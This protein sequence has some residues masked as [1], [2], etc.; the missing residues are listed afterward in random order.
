LDVDAFDPANLQQIFERMQLAPQRLVGELEDLVERSYQHSTGKDFHEA[1]KNTLQAFRQEMVP[2]VS[3]SQRSSQGI[4]DSPPDLISRNPFH[5]KI[6]SPTMSSAQDKNA[7]VDSSIIP[8]SDRILEKMPQVQVIPN[9]VYIADD[10]Q[11]VS[12]W[13]TIN[14]TD[15]NETQFGYQIEDTGT[16]ENS[17]QPASNEAM[18]RSYAVSDKATTSSDHNFTPSNSST[19]SCVG[20]N[21]KSCAVLATVLS[22]SESE[23]GYDS[24]EDTYSSVA[25]QSCAYTDTAQWWGSAE[26]QNARPVSGSSSAQIS[27]SGSNPFISSTRQSSS[28]M[29][30]RKNGSKRRRDDRDGDEDGDGTN[31]EGKDKEGSIDDQLRLACPFYARAPW[32]ARK[33]RSCR[34]PG[35]PTVH[36]LK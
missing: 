33:E 21:D 7:M 6:S 13:P 29:R 28:A 3:P 9:G 22:S 5:K 19:T 15:S 36:R 10:P 25:N 27:A 16:E 26:G 12:L 14:Q 32:K 8:T 1:I 2:H 34:G 18:P 24:S 31:R 30:K 11:T 35:W 4:G 17:S 20:S 23:G